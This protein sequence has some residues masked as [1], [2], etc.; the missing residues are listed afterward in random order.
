MK[1]LLTIIII[2][3]FSSNA[4][5]YTVKGNH[6]CGDIINGNKTDDDMLYQAIASWTQGYITA[7]NFVSDFELGKNASFHSLYYA[8]LNFCE[9]NP[10][11]DIDDAARFIYSQFED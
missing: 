3:L 11:K 6:E 8:V 10:L 2:I 1:K 4:F 7:R 9:D 5:C